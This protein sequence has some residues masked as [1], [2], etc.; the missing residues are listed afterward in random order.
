MTTQEIME[1]LN[2]SISYMFDE[3]TKPAP[4]LEQTPA[5]AA[6]SAEDYGFPPE[7]GKL[8]LEVH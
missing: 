2:H 3:L 1:Q 8:F 4:A 6:P 7:P 5:T